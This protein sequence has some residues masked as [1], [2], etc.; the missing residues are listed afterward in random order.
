MYL[1]RGSCQNARHVSWQLYG[2][3]KP[4][5]YTA[6]ATPLICNPD[7]TAGCCHL[8]WGAP[9]SSPALAQAVAPLCLGNARR[10][11]HSCTDV[12]EGNS[13]CP[14][15]PSLPPCLGWREFPVGVAWCPANSRGQGRLSWDWS[16]AQ[17]LTAGGEPPFGL[18]SGFSL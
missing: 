4:S 16:T 3:A 18:V 9:A 17:E 8:S 5:T 11:W 14:A 12:R 6:P 7:P 10:Q 15:G 2:E 13:L 1:W